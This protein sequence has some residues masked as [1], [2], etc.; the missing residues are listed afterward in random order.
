MKSTIMTAI[1]E[2]AV[3]R[4]REIGVEVNRAQLA[5]IE[6]FLRYKK[7]PFYLEPLTAN[8]TYRDLSDLEVAC[9]GK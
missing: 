4:V 2:S 6:K 9:E 1:N 5:E 8:P 7:I 3:V